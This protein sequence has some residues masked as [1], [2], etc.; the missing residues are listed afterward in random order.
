MSAVSKLVLSLGIVVLAAGCV[1]PAIAP[2]PYAVP[3]EVRSEIG[4]LAVRAPSHPKVSLTEQIDNR[5]EAAGRT[6]RTASADWLGASLNA[7][8]TS[9]NAFGGLFIAALGL[10]TTPI[11][12]AGGAAYGA[13]A[14]DSEETIQESNRFLAGAFGFTPA[15]FQRSLESAFED[16][17]LKIAFVESSVSDQ[18]LA[19]R[20]FDSVLDVRMNSIA[21]LP[22]ANQFEVSLNLHNTLILT[23]LAD[24]AELA[25]REYRDTTVSHKL[26]HWTD[27]NGAAVIAQLDA[28]FSELSTDIGDE[29]FF[30]PSIRVA[31]MEPV[32]RRGY[33][34][35]NATVPMFVW[36]SWD[37][38]RDV[39]SELSYEFQLF[40]KGTE[41]TEVLTTEGARFV[42]SEPLLRC[43]RYHWRVRA[44]YLYF[45]QSV[46]SDWSPDYRFRTSCAKN[47]K[48]WS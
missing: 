47:R 6:A 40:Q 3:N 15:S 20:G 19:D 27:S 37:G 45:G 4:W 24:R 31:G 21:T 9:D 2:Q 5:G 33:G 32:S 11:V 26:S 7:A 43:T 36:Q 39:S 12:A 13:A 23:R 44:R 38:S 41:P 46:L 16:A 22:S 29:L 10:V 1:S 34:K 28:E 30:R 35:I 14:A 18:Q 42:P 48:A 25:R 17:P 8:S